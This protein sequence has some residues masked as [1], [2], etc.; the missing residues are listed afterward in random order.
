MDRKTT[1]KAMALLTFFL[2]RDPLAICVKK[3][4]GLQKNPISLSPLAYGNLILPGKKYRLN[5]FVTYSTYK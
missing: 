3:T 2:I 4:A 1:L 5:P